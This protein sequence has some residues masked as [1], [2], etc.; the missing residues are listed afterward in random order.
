MIFRTKED[1]GSLHSRIVEALTQPKSSADIAT[2]IE[3]VGAANDQ[4]VAAVAECERSS[5]EPLTPPEAV[6]KARAD[7]VDL[8]FEQRRLA[9][10]LE[11]LN[12]RLGEVQEQERSAERIAEFERV[13]AS[14]EKLAKDLREIYP[15]AAGMIVNLC[16]RI[17]ENRREVDLFNRRRQEDDELI[18]PAEY[19]V[20]G[21][22]TG[23]YDNDFASFVRLPSIVEGHEMAPLWPPHERFIPGGRVGAFTVDDADDPAAAGIIEHSF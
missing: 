3:A 23:G 1:T 15:A 16:E 11:R 10:A 14:T 2:L 20:R 18:F 13:S 12:A 6:T 21:R 22:V 17:K 5:L 4:S 19:L 9:L 8:T 7:I